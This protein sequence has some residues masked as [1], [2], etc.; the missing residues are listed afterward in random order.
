M[1]KT[2]VIN[3]FDGGIAEDLRTTQTNQCEE[4][5]NFDIATKPHSLIPYSDPVAE[6]SSG[7]LTDYTITD[8]VGLLPNATNGPWQLFGLGRASSGSQ[9]ASIFKK[10]S[11]TDI[12]SAWG[13]PLV[14]VTGST[15]TIEV[16]PGTLTQYHGFLYFMSGSGTLQKFTSPTTITNIGTTASIDVGEPRKM[17]VHPYD[18]SLYMYGSNKVFKYDG[19]TYTTPT[20]LHNLGNDMEVSALCG[21]GSQLAIGVNRIYGAVTYPK[22][23][24][25]AFVYLSNK[26]ITTPQEKPQSVL[27]WGSE[28]LMVLDDIAGAIIGIS[29]TSNAAAYTTA[30]NKKIIVKASTGGTPVVLKELTTT[31]VNPIKVFKDKIN[32]R[33]YFG[34]DGDTNIWVVG[35]NK[36]GNFYVVKD[37]YLRPT[38]TAVTTLDGFNMVG[39][40]AFVADTHGGTAGYLTRQGTSTDYAL[41]SSYTTTIN[42]G[43]GGENNMFKKKIVKVRVSYTVNT[44]GGTVGVSLRKDRESSYT[45]V[46]SQTETTTGSHQFFAE[47]YADGTRFDEGYEFQFKLTSTGNV[48]IE[49]LEYEYDTIQQ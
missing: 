29:Y 26:D 25:Q 11:T 41:T 24:V 9:T 22:R 47:A 7:T 14:S 42:P 43:M 3:R 31:S 38:G 8:V 18:D 40:I 2:V 49:S 1:A 21:F 44:T 30:V 4:S 36:L 28:S 46:I 32:D 16:Q 19:V 12:T 27:P 6:T 34:F 37:R 35:K 20:E 17:F 10:A 15:G 13:S 48:T 45:S 23:G 33:L 39:D 5:L